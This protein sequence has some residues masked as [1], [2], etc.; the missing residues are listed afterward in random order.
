MLF[1]L[2]FSTKTLILLVRLIVFL[3]KKKN[4][5]TLLHLVFTN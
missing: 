5:L 1:S 4:V 3:L 2:G